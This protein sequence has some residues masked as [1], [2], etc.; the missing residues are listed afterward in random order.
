MAYLRLDPLPT[1]DYH[2]SRLGIRRVF[3]VWKGRVKNAIQTHESDYYCAIIGSASFNTISAIAASDILVLVSDLDCVCIYDSS[4]GTG[5]PSLPVISPPGDPR[6][7][8][9]APSC[10]CH[11]KYIDLSE[12]IP[13]ED[14]RFLHDVLRLQGNVTGVPLLPGELRVRIQQRIEG[15]PPLAPVLWRNLVLIWGLVKFLLYYDLPIESRIDGLYQ[16]AKGLRSDDDLRFVDIAESPLIYSVEQLT[17]LLAS[18]TAE[19]LGLLHSLPRLQI[20]TRLGDVLE[21]VC[22]DDAWMNLVLGRDERRRCLRALI[23]LVNEFH[24]VSRVATFVDRAI[25]EFGE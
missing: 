22:Q 9:L 6:S 10:Q 17:G 2:L 3:E 20:R 11:I 21:E 5:R 13:E 16:L 14:I 1:A 12:H 23:P 19:Y 18:C 25:E 24:G 7:F 15:T 8:L 4:R